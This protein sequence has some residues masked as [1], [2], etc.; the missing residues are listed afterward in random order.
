MKESQAFF[1][2]RESSAVFAPIE[3]GFKTEEKAKV[4]AAVWWA[5]FQFT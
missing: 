2:K 3:E 1:D 4:L 5:E